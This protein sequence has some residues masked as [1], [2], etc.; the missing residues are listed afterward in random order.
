MPTGE[1]AQNLVGQRSKPATPRQELITS[2]KSP[3][4]QK[5]WLELIKQIRE[6]FLGEVTFVE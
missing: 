6:D 5:E 1:G 4:V 2:I 3:G